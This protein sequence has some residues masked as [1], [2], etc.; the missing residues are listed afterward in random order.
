MLRA[1]IDR[2]VEQWEDPKGPKKDP[3]P[4]AKDGVDKPNKDD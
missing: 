4:P 2:I 3:K 1:E